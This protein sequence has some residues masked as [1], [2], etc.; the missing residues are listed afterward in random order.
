MVDGSCWAWVMGIWGWLCYYAIFVYVLKWEN[1]EESGLC[2]LKIICIWYC[3]ACFCSQPRGTF[4]ERSS[5]EPALWLWM[6]YG[7]GIY[8]FSGYER[9]WSFVLLFHSAWEV[10]GNLCIIRWLKLF[11]PRHQ[12]PSL[13]SISFMYIRG[14]SEFR[15]LCHLLTN[16]GQVYHKGGRKNTRKSI[17]FAIRP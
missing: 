13:L 1:Y 11:L 2:K 12:K 17:A 6:S 10:K 16:P 4:F 8:V 7:I 5:E 15:G 3:F 14:W 9:Y